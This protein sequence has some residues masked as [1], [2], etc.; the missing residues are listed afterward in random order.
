MNNNCEFSMINGNSIDINPHE[1][2]SEIKADVI[3]SEFNSVRIWG[4]IM[5]CKGESVP[6]ALIKLIR[7]A[8]DCKDTEACTYQGI[9]H[10]VS[11]CQGF[12]QFDIEVNNSKEEFKILVGKSATGTERIIAPN[13]GNCDACSGDNYRPSSE[14]V[15]KVTPPDKFNCQTK[16][17]VIKF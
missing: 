6:N 2:D 12:Y 9:A 17:N 4:Q 16:P 13:T 3:V 5:N 15:Y 8:K 1:G 14:Y 11:D 10:T 7:I